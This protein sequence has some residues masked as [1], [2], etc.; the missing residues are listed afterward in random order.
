MT[1]PARYPSQEG[2]FE[3]KLLLVDRIGGLCLPLFDLGIIY[4]ANP[5]RI[6]HEI[7]CLPVPDF[8][9]YQC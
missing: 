2:G 1:Q 4:S 7:D 8:S 3:P 5:I 6:E 9:D